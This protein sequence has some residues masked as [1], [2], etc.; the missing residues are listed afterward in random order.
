M[1]NFFYVKS[2]KFEKVREM[3]ILRLRVPLL[4][5]TLIKHQMVRG[6]VRSQRLV[7]KMPTYNT[8][9]VKIV[10][11]SFILDVENLF[12]LTVAQIILNQFCLKIQECFLAIY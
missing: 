8:I 7:N 10:Y 2:T 3:L 9:Q 1:G 5:R 11:L 6:Y 12:L 4:L